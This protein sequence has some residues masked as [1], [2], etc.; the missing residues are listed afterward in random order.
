MKPQIFSN[1]YVIY[2]EEKPCKNHSYDLMVWYWQLGINK[3]G[4]KII[5]FS[6]RVKKTKQTLH[7]VRLS[8]LLLFCSYFQTKVSLWWF[9][10]SV[11]SGSSVWVVGESGVRGSL[12]VGLE[13]EDLRRY[14]SISCCTI[15]SP[16]CSN[17]GFSISPLRSAAERGIDVED[18]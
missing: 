14:S 10:G 5:L 17:T 6:T 8:R 18:L 16:D 7:K 11:S 15:C 12:V 3:Y 2:N 9:W 4:K 13:E 1:D